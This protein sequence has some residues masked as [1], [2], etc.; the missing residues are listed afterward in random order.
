MIR[1]IDNGHIYESLVPDGTTW[2]GV[3][4]LIKAVHEAFDAE[5]QA[6]KSS[7]NTRSK[8]YGIPVQ[9]I[10]AAWDN[11]RNRAS[12]LGHWYHDMREKELWAKGVVD[13]LPVIRSEMV[14]GIKVAPEQKLTDGIYPEHLIY[15]PALGVCGQSDVVKIEKGYISI[16][17]FKTS[18][19]IATSSYTN[20]EGNSKKMLPPLQ[21]LDDCNLNHYALQLSIY[22]Y[23]VIRHNPRLQAGNMWIDHIKFVEAGKDKYGYPI[24]HIDSDGNPI[25]EEIIKIPVPYMKGEVQKLFEWLKKPDN[26]NSIIKH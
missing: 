7:K 26:R 4:S 20:W 6:P 3:T 24:H 19:E 18:K 21:H 15:I 14:D 12:E 10:L 17:D 23:G 16:S 9:E 5:K 1:Y 2:I 8:W 25:V 13:G 11:E 22:M